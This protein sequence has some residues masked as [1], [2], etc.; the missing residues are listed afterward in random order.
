MVMVVAG[1]KY[2][3]ELPQLLHSPTFTRKAMN[4]HTRDI[5]NKLQL[6]LNFVNKRIRKLEENLVKAYKER[7]E[8]ESLQEKV[9]QP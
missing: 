9:K 7:H 4:K 3:L 8:I 2:R 6:K 1:T 5:E